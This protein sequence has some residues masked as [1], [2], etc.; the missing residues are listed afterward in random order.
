M[1][2]EIGTALIFIAV[3]FVM[4]TFTTKNDVR[5]MEELEKR[6]VLREER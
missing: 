4:R 1:Y 5:K 3:L 2:G 6:E